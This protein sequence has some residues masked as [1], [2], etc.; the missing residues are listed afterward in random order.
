M[1]SKNEIFVLLL[2]VSCLLSF[3]SFTQGKANIK[4]V[5]NEPFK[6]SFIKDYPI[7]IDGGC[8]FYTYDTTSFNEQKYIFIVSVKDVAFMNIKDTYIYL[9][10]TKRRELQ[11]NEYEDS[12]LGEGYKV[13]LITAQTSEIHDHSSLYDGTLQVNH[14]GLVWNFKIHGKVDSF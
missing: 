2:T 4:S 10:K 3:N 12:F 9:K 8:S 1:K 11:K 14:N 5:T 7:K 6:F 13:I